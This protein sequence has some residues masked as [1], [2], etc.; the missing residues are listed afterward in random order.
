MGVKE[1]NVLINEHVTS[2]TRCVS[3]LLG[4][5]NSR[6][7]KNPDQRPLY[8]YHTTNDEY[9]AL[10]YLLSEQ[11]PFGQ[12]LKDKAACACFALYCSEWYRREYQRDHGWSWDPIWQRLTFTLTP[13][14]L[15][16][17]V[18][19]GLEEYWKRPIRFYESDRRNFLGSLFSE[20][21]LPFQLLKESDSRFQ[22]LFSRILKHYDQWHLMGYSTYQQV[23]ELMEKAGL[24]QSFSE[25]TSIELIA[26]MADRLVYL[27]RD[28]GLDGNTEPVCKLDGANPRWREGFPLPLDNH[29]GTELLN[30]LLK[31]ASSETK[32]C[33]RLAGGWSCQHF[34]SESSQDKFNVLVSMP[35]EVT[36][37]LDATPPTTRFELALVEG[38]QEIALLGPGYAVVEN[39]VAKVRV[40]SRE[41]AALRR[42][43]ASKLNLIALA[44]GLVIASIPIEDSVIG[45]GDV[46]VGFARI[47]DRWQLCGQASFTTQNEDVLI[48]LPNN[49]AL[50]DNDD[51]IS[52]GPSVCSFRTIKV[53]GKAELH[54]DG[55]ELFRIRTGHA[56]S[57]DPRLDF[58]GPQIE[59]PTKPGL[60]FLGTPRVQ[61]A[62]EG[63]ELLAKGSK[64]F[65]AGKSQEACG[66]QETL[67]VQYL[68]VRNQ[69]GETLLRRRV[70][71][72]PADFKLELKR[73][74]DAHQG[75]ILIYT[76][77][78]CLY[79]VEGAEIQINRVKYERYTELML[80]ASGLPPAKVILSVTPNLL[81]DPIEIE[82]PFPSGGCLAFDSHGKRLKRELSVD[83]LLGVRVYLFARGSVPTKY[84][85]ELSL[86]GNVARHAYYR[87]SYTVKDKPLEISL[88]NM[89][90]QIEDLLSLESGIDQ[91]VDLRIENTYFRI[92]K[93]AAEMKI[94]YGRQTLVLL[95]TYNINGM[96]PEPEIMLLHDPMRKPVMLASK[97]S[98]GVPTGEFELPE[99]IDRNGPWLV[100]PKKGSMVSFR[101]LFVPGGRI[102]PAEVRDVQSLQKAVQAFVH[103]DDVSS[104]VSVLDAMA[105]NPMHSGWQF[106]RSQYEQFGYLPM[107][108]FEAWKALIHHPRALAMALFKFEMDPQFLG[109]IETEFP[110]FWEFF[111]LK[112]I[113]SA[114]TCFGD[115]LR[116]KGVS[117]ETVDDLLERMLRR[118]GEVFPVYGEDIQRYLSGRSL[119]P[120]THIP[121]KV[122]EMLVEGWYQDLIRDR[123]DA[124]WPEYEGDRLQDWCLSQPDNV[125][126]FQPE[127]GFRNTVVY[128]PVFAAAVASGRVEASEIFDGGGEAV[129]FLRQVRAFD[130]RWFNPLYEYC[131]L[132]NML[133]NEKDLS[134]NG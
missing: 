120:E 17:V 101:P 123:S 78:P 24:P 33:Q 96:L 89:R 4:Y 7:I 9:R 1:G 102:H 128:L 132:N 29:T 66:F 69:Q 52:M 25:D 81:G 98:E 80:S 77:Q 43:C 104:F 103:S 133:A 88:F 50:R 53:S 47:N 118:L 45:L 79:K 12:S 55:D 11:K 30:G 75:S 125:I 90:D 92:R 110:F 6:G 27:V 35:E 99:L 127:M 84:D 64:L 10:H 97:T 122:F 73:G 22:T 3:W 23:E 119:G 21:G 67:G 116:E 15:R 70:G 8:E 41:I 36:F 57:T 19:I 31:T 38:E 59:W 63:G 126:R 46:P 62:N 94:D 18:P 105:A 107:A 85:L 14:E 32:K 56:L 82:V 37:H 72:L 111:P 130:V 108:T 86:H 87:W 95:D 2:G 117:D 44:G 74:G 106:F 115:F 58:N 60:V 91:V 42:D 68:S 48:V 61:W 121:I 26:G 39:G 54:V 134:T 112:E 49:S 40:R 76:E 20:G 114:A 16:R 109:R 5:L 65:I 131:L 83:E 129:F 124:H 100:I 51:D 71:I 93:Y 13:L 34:W 113:R 28:Y